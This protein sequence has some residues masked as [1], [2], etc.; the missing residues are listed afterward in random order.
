MATF[1]AKYSSLSGETVP[2]KF[3]A[4][5]YST[6]LTQACQY[7]EDHRGDSLGLMDIIE[8]ER[9]PKVPVTTITYLVKHG[10]T[11]EECRAVYENMKAGEAAVKFLKFF[12]GMDIVPLDIVEKMEEEG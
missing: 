2:M 10:A 12:G 7:L 9:A 1:N 4:P 6:A 5:S 8:L 11:K 3:T